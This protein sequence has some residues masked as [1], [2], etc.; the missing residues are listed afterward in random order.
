MVKSIL[1]PSFR[2]V[3]AAET[4]PE[5]MRAKFK[6]MIR[7]QKEREQSIKA[8]AAVKVKPLKGKA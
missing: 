3:K 6:K 1:D 2:Y 5:Y 4:T 7:E 8:E